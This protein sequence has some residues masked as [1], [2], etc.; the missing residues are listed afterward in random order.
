VQDSNFH[1]AAVFEKEFAK[2]IQR[3]ASH[4]YAITGMKFVALVAPGDFAAQEANLKLATTSDRT[5]PHL[6]VTLSKRCD[7][8]LPRCSPLQ[9]YPHFDASKR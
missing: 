6:D 2:D 1:T 4:C 5:W 8:S 3:E 9:T 7:P